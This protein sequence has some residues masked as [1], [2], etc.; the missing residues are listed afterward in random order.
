MCVLHSAHLNL[1]LLT[2]WAKKDTKKTSMF[3][4]FYITGDYD[5]SSRI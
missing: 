4:D 3:Y 2:S 5:G 1:K